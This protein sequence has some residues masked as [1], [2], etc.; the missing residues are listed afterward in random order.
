[1]C[2]CVVKMSKRVNIEIK[3][4]QF[5]SCASEL[6]HSLYVKWVFFFIIQTHSRMNSRNFTIFPLNSN[7]F[8]LVTIFVFLNSF[9]LRFY[10]DLFHLDCERM[11]FR[12]HFSSFF[13]FHSNFIVSS[14]RLGFVYKTTVKWMIWSATFQ[15]YSR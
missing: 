8:F 7:F 4:T 14:V 2:Q 6:F 10:L 9:F 1:M 11:Y 3:Q 13:F 5:S 15:T 12:I